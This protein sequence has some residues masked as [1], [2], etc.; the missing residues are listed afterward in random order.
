[1]LRPLLQDP[2]KRSEVLATLQAVSDVAVE[3]GVQTPSQR[4]IM[5]TVTPPLVQTSQVPNESGVSSELQMALQTATERR[6]EIR[7]TFME[8][9]RNAET[10]EEFVRHWR[11]LTLFQSMFYSVGGDTGLYRWFAAVY[12]LQGGPD[13]AQQDIVRTIAHLVPLSPTGEP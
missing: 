9:T 10:L 12:G 7:N 8:A 3:S 6:I 13:Q 11:V 2:S 1:A 5:Q 4:L